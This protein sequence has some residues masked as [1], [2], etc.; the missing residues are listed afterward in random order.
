[1][2]HQQRRQ[3]SAAA[4]TSATSAAPCAWALQEC[5]LKPGTWPTSCTA[6]DVISERHRHR[7]EFNN[8]YRSSWSAAGLVISAS[9]WT[10]CWS[11]WSSCP[12]CHPWFLACQFHPEFLSTPRDGPSAVRRLRPRAAR[13]SARLAAASGCSEAAP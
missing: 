3:S 9:R 7:Y 12:G 10:T 4:R 13:A 8:R 2:A 5:R 1:M 6:S 11:R